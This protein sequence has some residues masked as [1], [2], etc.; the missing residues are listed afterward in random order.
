MTKTNKSSLSENSKGKK[1]SRKFNFID[2]LIILAVLLLAAIV[3]N[4][5]T[6]LSLF[7]ERLKKENVT[8]Q[9]TVEFTNVDQSFVDKIKEYDNVVDSVSKFSLG[10]VAAVDASTNYTELKYSESTGTG[11]VA[12]Y[13]DRY[14][15]LVT[16]TVE[17]TYESG[18]GYAVR[19]KRIAVGEK[20][21]LR[22][23]DYAGEGYCI[24]VLV[25]END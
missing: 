21:A 19:D 18:E 12:T 2:L 7:G 23:P 10:K 25:A 20:M 16:I 3:I 8:V 22:F 5:F 14:N 6:P 1:Q 4:I 13:P 17:A 11:I 15:L 24:D 9:Y